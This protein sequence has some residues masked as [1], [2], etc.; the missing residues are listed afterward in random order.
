MLDVGCWMQH[1]QHP[2][3]NIPLRAHGT[4]SVRREVYGRKARQ[5]NVLLI[6]GGGREHAIAWKLRQ[7]PKLGEL[8]VAPGNGGIASIAD[9]VPLAIPKPDASPTDA[10]A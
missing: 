1:F 7:S 2:T 3:S 6:G 8:T 5:M 10:A 9:C 4:G